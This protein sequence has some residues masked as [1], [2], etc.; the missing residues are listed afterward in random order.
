[1]MDGKVVKGRSLPAPRLKRDLWLRGRGP[2]GGMWVLCNIRI[3]ARPNVL[4][5][6]LEIDLTNE[7]EEDF[8][9]NL[10]FAT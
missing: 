1:V 5:R 9:G 2:R 7:A 6:T 10:R 3:M 4:R 8:R